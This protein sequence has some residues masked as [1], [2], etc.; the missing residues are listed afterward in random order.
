MARRAKENLPGGSLKYQ[1]VYIRIFRCSYRSFEMIVNI[2]DLVKSCLWSYHC[3][4][5]IT[6]HHHVCS[7]EHWRR[8]FFVVWLVVWN[9][10]FIFIFSWEFHHPNWR[11]PSF[12]RGVG[13]PPTSCVFNHRFAEDCHGHGQHLRLAATHRRGHDD[14]LRWESHEIPHGDGS[15]PM[16][17]HIF[18]GDKWG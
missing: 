8:F 13:I 4:Y 15:R 16:E 17:N 3:L 7:F 10:N 5:H 9:M 18:A 6:L 1:F 2:G 12:F 11:T 14:L